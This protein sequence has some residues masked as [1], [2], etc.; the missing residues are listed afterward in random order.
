MVKR[1]FAAAVLAAFAAAAYLLW[2]GPALLS[3]AAASQT[4]RAADDLE[5]PL[6]EL[7][8]FSEVYAAIKTKYVDEVSD[9]EIFEAAIRGM[10]Q[11]LDPHSSYFN[12]ADYRDF[13][14]GL[15]GVFGGIGIFIGL[16][17]GLVE[18]VSPIEG[19]PAERAGVLAGDLISK[20]NGAPVRGMSVDEAAG[21]MRGEPGTNVTLEII[22]P[23][24]SAPLHFDLTREEIK[25]PSIRSA[26]ADIDYGYLRVT[27]FQPER[28]VADLVR[29]LDRLYEENNG[30][31]RGLILDLRNNPGG[32]LHSSIGVASVFLPAGA[33]VVSDRGRSGR[34]NIHSAGRHAYPADG[35]TRDAEAKTV[36]MVI[37]IN[38]G[39]ASAAEIVA[40]ALQDH[41]RAVLVGARSYGKAS[42]QAI[43]LLQ[44][45]RFST[46]IKLTAA[47]YFTPKG[48]SIQARGIDPDVPVARAT[49]ERR[50]EFGLRE[51]DFVDH[52]EAEEQNGDDAA[53]EN[54][55][56]IPDI[57]APD[58]GESPFLPQD[59][60]QFEQA[61]NILKA[62]HAVAQQRGE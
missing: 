22:R 43:H 13:Q 55:E 51:S 21:I 8:E 44:A 56:S 14:E 1:F 24:E 2:S 52:L 31:L 32:D 35:F 40:G 37:L 41:D 16:K 28:T 50:P 3:F 45:T 6:G 17:S 60:Y 38:G 26:F 59:D 19:T 9:R 4:A 49:I 53:E 29:H 48:R 36:P 5:L 39:S 61:L 42:V 12:E 23:G 15:T 20:L 11:G 57:A 30:A 33:E 7:R 47:R 46:A 10:L 58:G 34:L 27:Q 18:V 62:L 54:A 25:T